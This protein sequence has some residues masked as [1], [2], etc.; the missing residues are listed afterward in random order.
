MFVGTLWDK[1]PKSK[2]IV[3]LNRFYKINFK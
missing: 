3:S 2:K 1:L